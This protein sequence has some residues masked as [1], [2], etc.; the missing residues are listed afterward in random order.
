MLKSLQILN[1]ALS[2]KGWAPQ[3]RPA[4]FSK[5][6]PKW[7]FHG[8][9]FSKK[10]QELNLTQFATKDLGTSVETCKKSQTNFPN[11]IFMEQFF[12]KKAREL[13]LSQFATKLFFCIWFINYWG[14]LNKAKYPHSEGIT[15]KRENPFLWL[16]L[17]WAAKFPKSNKFPKTELL[18]FSNFCR[19]ASVKGCSVWNVG[20]PLFCGV[21]GQ[22]SWWVPG[23]SHMQIR[24]VFCHE[25]E[26]IRNLGIHHH[27]KMAVFVFNVVW[28]W[29]VWYIS[30]FK[31]LTQ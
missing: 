17:I 18:P 31:N 1:H 27:S 22:L 3:L 6:I 8:T 19:S 21:L 14:K 9:S 24:Y 29:F 28:N 16:V 4:K 20:A 7:H 25:I 12:S 26:F 30:S 11:G 5:K 23:S 2:M 15:Y 10:A 13:N